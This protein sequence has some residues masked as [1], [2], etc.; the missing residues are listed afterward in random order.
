VPRVIRMA[1]EYDGTCYYGFA[2]QPGLPTIQEVMERALADLFG[3]PV[4]VTP[5]GRT[6]AG[7]HAR[8]QVLSFRTEAR[9]PAE[10]IS[11]AVNARLPGDIVAGVA[12]EV[13]PGFDARRSARRRHYR[14]TIWN[15][16][17]PNLWL[18]RYSLHLAG[19]LDEIAMADAAAALLGRHDFSSFI[20]HA[21]RQPEASSPMRTIERAEWRREGDLLH[22]ECSANAF[23]RH[24][25][26]T[27]VGTM[28]WVGR[29]RLSGERFR[30]IL[31]ARDRRAA[32]P[33]VPPG[34]L[35]LVKVDYDRES[36][37]DQDI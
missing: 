34:G 13:E 27:L 29:G 25:V 30:H 22:F 3:Y 23:A 20:G 8:G 2:R 21:A 12:R 26:R 19:A 16:D 14:Y 5:G 18:R 31:A 17:R 1:L 6:D 24:M 37:R 7:V 11:A 15:R 4:P 9:M 33:T 32:G 28:L 10:A 36:Q 35:T